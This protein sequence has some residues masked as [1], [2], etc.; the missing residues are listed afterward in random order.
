VKPKERTDMTEPLDAPHLP[1][2]VRV[3]QTHLRLPSQPSWIE[4]AVDFLKT[5]ALMCGA[6][7]ESRTGK[8][9]VALHEALNNAVVHGNLEI[10]SEL[11]ERG[12]DAYAR[13]LAAQ[14]TDPR[15]SRRTVD[16][17][18]DYDGQRCQWAIT[19]QGAGFDV[20]SV[21]RRAASDEP[22]V[23]LASG[24]GILMMRSFMDELRYEAG[25]R[26][27]ILTLRKK[28]GEETRHQE[29][30]P[31]NTPLRVA[32]VRA[33]GSV[34]WDAAYAAVSRNL[35]VE[36]I[37]FLQAHLAV[38]GRVLLGLEVGEELVYVPAE[39][40]HWRALGE[41]VVELGCRFQASSSVSPGADVGA[42]VG[43]LLDQAKGTPHHDDRRHYPRVPYSDTVEI[44]VSAAAAPLP[45]YP[46][47]LSKG[48][49]AF[50]TTVALPPAFTVVFPARGEEPALCLRAEI[51]R[52]ARVQEGF[53]DVAARFVDFAEGHPATRDGDAKENR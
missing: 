48:G 39:V 25:G 44:H 49:I 41:D 28:S 1:G 43:R 38:T 35:S 42:A 13:A 14:S 46:R 15:F 29:R 17:V 10:S 20:E 45:G 51:V 26:R 31:I 47:N 2:A 50:I 36:G 52:S 12:D 3:E 8:L 32:P 5:K 40:R 22:D 34:D 6:C 4:P 24:R 7:Q 53:Y 37:G 11:K 27:V 16:I 21:L 30:L 19:D 18:V 9:L 33:D 23:L